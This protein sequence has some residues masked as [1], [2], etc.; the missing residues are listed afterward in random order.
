MKKRKRSLANRLLIMRRK[1]PSNQLMIILSLIVGLLSG[2]VAVIIKNLVF[3]IQRLLTSGFTSDYS[4]IRYVFYP[5]VGIFL[6]IL[7]I[8][9]ILRRPVRD[10]IPNVLYSISKT[11]GKISTHNTFSSVITSALTVGFGGSVGLEGPAVVTGAAIGSTL[12]KM[13]GLSYKQTV[14]VLGFAAAAAMSA[15]FKAPIAAIVFALE[16]ILFDMTMTALVPLLLASIVAALTSYAFLGQNVLYPFQVQYEFN[17]SETFYYFGLGVFTAMVSVYYIKGYVYSGK[18]FDKIPGWVRKFLTGAGILGLLIFLF[19][20][21]YG[22]GYEAI[23][24]ALKGNLSFIFDNSIFYNFKENE[25]FALLLL[26]G[27][28]I[29]K[30]V[31][32]SVTFRAGGIGGIF[33]PTL[34]IGAMTGLFFAK[35]LGYIGIIDLPISDFVLVGMAGLIA[36]VVHA[37]LTAIF[38]IAEITGGYSLLFPIMIVATTSYGITRMIS[39]HSIYTLQLSKRGDMLTHH[40]DKAL[41][42]MMSIEP[43]IEKNFDTISPDANLGDLVKVIS[44]STRNIYPVVDEE[45]N[46]FGIVIM[47]QIRHLMFQPEM[48]ESTSVRDLLFHP[49]SIV[50]LTDDMETVAHKF[51]HSGKYN[52]AVLDGNK[53]VGFVSRANVFSQYRQLLKDFSED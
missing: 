46:F 28:I 34:F 33:A 13:L 39:P 8:K 15:I 37:P 44:D 19:P 31:A 16:V 20:S 35:F 26:L 50:Y 48:Y 53:Y 22:E 5:A 30:V 7:F 47:D 40:K 14:T 25:G 45:S 27:I 32:T 4:N 21:L 49:S 9:Y 11:H 43:L 18:L 3:L 42:S 24:T 12:A 52:L 36:G 6:V 10:G 29:L 2:L 38:L 41:L 17:L 23:N 1:M 51:Q